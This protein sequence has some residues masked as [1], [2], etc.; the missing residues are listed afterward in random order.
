MADYKA[1][2]SYLSQHN[3][4]HFTFYSQSDK[5]IKA[6]IHGLPINTYSQDVTLALQELGYNVISIKQM[7]TKHSSPDCSI[8]TVS[9]TLACS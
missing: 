3:P 5:S 8:K 4:L 1:I 2:P 6:V 7:V 9:L